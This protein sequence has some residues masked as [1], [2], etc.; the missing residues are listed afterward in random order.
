MSVKRK[1]GGNLLKKLIAATALLLAM[2]LLGARADISLYAQAGALAGTRADGFIRVLEEALDERVVLV[3]GEQDRNLSGLILEDRAPHLAIVHVNQA[4]ALAREGLLLPLESCAQGFEYAA[5]PLMD[6]CALEGSLFALPLFTRERRMAVNPELLDAAAL[7][8]LLDRH[9]HP[10]LYPSEFA[11]ALEELALYGGAGLRIWLP[12]EE[13]ELWIEALLQGI[14]GFCLYDETSGA[15]A[16]HRE[17][18]DALLWLQD[19]IGAGLIDAAP[20]REAALVAFV[21]G[22]TAFFPDWSDAE[23]AKYEEM[24]GSGEIV[25][26]PYPS[27]YGEAV[28]AADLYV[29]CALDSGEAARNERIL[30]A[31]ALLA[32]G[33]WMT[34]LS[35]HRGIDEDGEP[36]LLADAAGDGAAL[37]ALMYDAARTAM[38][39]GDTQQAAGAAVRAMNAMGH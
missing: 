3:S 1:Q 28:H 7:G 37:R 13:R 32:G 4:Q 39:G 33:E 11:Q 20:D 16:Q 23:T 9:S 21:D 38:T 17:I 27:L 14:G 29:L 15:F 30:R 36:W 12:Q 6:A 18:E 8:H 5:Q 24:I 35:A 34:A 22:E 25:F 10:V 26:L 2:P 19:M 31:A